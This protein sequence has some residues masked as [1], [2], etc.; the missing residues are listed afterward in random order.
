VPGRCSCSGSTMRMGRSCAARDAFPRGDGAFG[1]EDKVLDAAELAAARASD[2]LLRFFIHP[3]SRRGGTGKAGGD[4]P[5]SWRRAASAHW[6]ITG[7]RGGAALR[8]ASIR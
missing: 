5:V 6:C 3:V 8:P 4:P 1:S 2:Y 7:T